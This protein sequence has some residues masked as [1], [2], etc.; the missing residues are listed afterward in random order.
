MRLDGGDVDKD[1]DLTMTKGRLAF[2]DPEKG[3][4]LDV[5]QLYFSKE[6]SQG[7]RRERLNT[8][9]LEVVKGGIR[10]QVLDE[11][12]RI[13]FTA[14]AWEISNADHLLILNNLFASCV[15]TLTSGVFRDAE[16]GQDPAKRIDRR[17][18]AQELIDR[19]KNMMIDSEGK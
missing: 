2:I 11:I 8:A 12:A 19:Y 3:T 13:V 18:V 1:R 16:A 4:G 10:G 6:Q 9:Q 7:Q 17:K 5:S 14:K 15:V